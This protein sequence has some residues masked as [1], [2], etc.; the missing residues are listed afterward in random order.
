ML[1]LLGGLFSL[2]LA[3]IER[4]PFVYALIAGIFAFGG[5][6]FIMV[7]ASKLREAGWL[8]FPFRKPTRDWGRQLYV[9]QISA[10]FA[11]FET[12]R[13]VE[14]GIIAFNGSDKAVKISA[15]SGWVS[16]RT[17]DDGA[18]L[19]TLPPPAFSVSSVKSIIPP[20][21]EFVVVLEQRILSSNAVKLNAALIRDGGATF[22]LRSLSI[23]LEL[24]DTTEK[25]AYRLPTWQAIRVQRFGSFIST[26]AE[27]Y[28][29]INV[30]L[31]A[32]T[33]TKAE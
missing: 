7:Q 1:P 11:Q 32:S 28:A 24:A 16:L 12:D 26:N 9:G 21:T 5:I 23:M 4:L 3:I 29:E 31:S 13:C 15:L 25:T 19:E 33:H 20:Q 30:T 6:L 27:I 2:M 8:P 22:D 17:E 18:T 10:G 14:I